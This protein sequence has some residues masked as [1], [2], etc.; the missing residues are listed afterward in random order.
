MPACCGARRPDVEAADQRCLGTV[1]FGDDDSP[2]AGLARGNQGRQHA[3]DRSQPT[4]EA[5]LGDPRQPGDGVARDGL[6]GGQHGHGECQ[7]EAGAGLAHIGGQQCDRDA[8]IRPLGAGV[9][10]RRAYAIPRFDDRDVGQPGERES[11]QACRKIGFD[12]DDLAGDTRERQSERARHHHPST[13]RRCR[14]LVAPRGGRS[15]DTTSNR[16]SG[17]KRGSP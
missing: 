17:Q 9:E 2:D 13:P 8:P 11:G 6:C 14:T 10:D 5:K 7:V 16:S 15:T 1:R 4:V 3:A 12:L